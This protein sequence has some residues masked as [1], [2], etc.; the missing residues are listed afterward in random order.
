MVASTKDAEKSNVVVYGNNKKI[1]VTGIENGIAYVYTPES[2]KLINNTAIIGTTT[3]D[4]EKGIYIVKIVE[5]DFSTVKKV[6]VK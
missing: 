6:I 4:I 5:E 2:G 1:V 3:I